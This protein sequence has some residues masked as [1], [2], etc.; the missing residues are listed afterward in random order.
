LEPAVT[1]RSDLKR[2]YK[3][4]RPAM[5]VF[6]VR[7][8]RNGRF[9]VHSAVNLKG[10]MNRLRVE[11]TPSTNPNVELLADWKAM[12]P[13]AFEIRVLDELEPKD[14]PGWDSTDDLAELKK[15][16]VERLVSEGGRPY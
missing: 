12:G 13:E 8:T 7:N 15:I 2:Q 16:W 1:D 11:I 5:G 10:G 6:V 14:E 4:S 9:I 3:E